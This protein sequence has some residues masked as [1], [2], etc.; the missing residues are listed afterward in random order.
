MNHLCQLLTDWRGSVP[1][2]GAWAE[3]KHDGWRALR[4]PGIDGIVRLW[5]RNGFVIEGAGHI[6]HRLDRIEAAMGEPMMFD[7]EFVVDGTLAATKAWCERGWKQGGEAGVLHLFDA[8]PL[9]EWRKGG[10]NTPLYRRKERLR[11]A[12]EATEADPWEWRPGSRGRDEG[13]AAVLLVQDFWAMDRGDVIDHAQR[14]WTA[15]GEG[16]VIKDAESG[17]QRKRSSAWAKVKQCNHKYW[18]TI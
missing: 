18:R 9:A 2:G 6:L 14:V 13:R 3:Q 16:L 10:T 8:V 4:F 11:G 17:Y 5:T 12:F 15:G 7:G 1:A